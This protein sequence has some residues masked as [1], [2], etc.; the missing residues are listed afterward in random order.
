LQQSPDIV[1][2]FKPFDNKFQWFIH[3]LVFSV[4]PGKL[5]AASTFSTET[6]P[7]AMSK[8]AFWPGLRKMSLMYSP[9]WLCVDGSFG[10][11]QESSN[12]RRLPFFKVSHREYF[13]AFF[14][15]LLYFLVN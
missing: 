13:A 3:E 15:K 10:N 2:V 7:A 6:E 4:Y 14:R 5:M 11:I 9:A 1:I 8:W 12:F